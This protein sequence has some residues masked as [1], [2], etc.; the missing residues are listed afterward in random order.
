V[1]ESPDATLREALQKAQ[2]E[3]AEAK[4]V[5]QTLIEREKAAEEKLTTAQ[6]TIKHYQEPIDLAGKTGRVVAVNPGWN[7]AV[8]DVGDRKGATLNAPLIVTRGGQMVGRLKITSV[9][10]ATSIADIIPGSVARGDS[11]Q[12]GDRIVFAGR[13]NPQAP[14]ETGPSDQKPAAGE[15]ANKQPGATQAPKLPER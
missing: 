7:F 11:V 13:S 12:P 5:Q 15:G 2:S 1:T 8:I 14:K 3:L 6:A 10:P 4:Q 9:E